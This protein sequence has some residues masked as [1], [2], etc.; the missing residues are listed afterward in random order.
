MTNL[1]AVYVQSQ[2][3]SALQ[4]LLPFLLIAVL[5]LVIFMP[6]QRRQ[7][8]WQQMLGQLKA[9][10]KVVTSGGIHGVIFSVRDDALVLR[11]PPDNLKI[12]VSRTAIASVITDESTKA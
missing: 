5:Y 6:Q 9:G 8:K 3:G 12:E 7:K 2:G 1:F 11:V 10:D 4:L